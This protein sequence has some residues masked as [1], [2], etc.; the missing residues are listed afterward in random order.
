MDWSALPPL[1]SL[2]SF[3]AAARHLG[4]SAAG[5]ELNVS[6]AAIAQQVRALETFLGVKLAERAGRGIVLTP[7]GVALAAGLREGFGAIA[8]AVHAAADTQAN[9]PLSITMTPSFAV[10]WFM[11]RMH[12]FREAHPGIELSINPTPVCVDLAGDRYD[13]AIRHGNGGWNN[14]ESE[15]LVRTRFVIAC[16]PDLVVGRTLRGP[17]DFLDLPWLQEFGT[18]ETSD[19]LVS[20]GITTSARSTINEMP[21]YMLLTALREGQ[22]IAATAR[23][24]IEDDLANGRLITLFEGADDT[25]KIY[26]LL[27]GRGPQRAALKQFLSWIR[28]AAN[29]PSCTIAPAPDSRAP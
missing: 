5:R 9:R 20:Q 19:W 12:L 8:D 24:F 2:R 29:D 16:A 22:G 17:E 15:P 14:L 26:H 6:H 7:T 23:I 3:E 4:F 13:A 1:A 27:Y 10:S 25:P 28:S 21:G 18:K 11:P